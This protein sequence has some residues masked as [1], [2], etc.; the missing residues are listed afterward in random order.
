MQHS[1]VKSMLPTVLCA[2]L[3]LMQLMLLFSVASRLCWWWLSHGQVRSDNHE[4]LS[5][6]STTL[7][8]FF[9]YF[10]PKAW[11]EIHLIRFHIL[12]VHPAFQSFETTWISILSSTVILLIYVI[13]CY[14][15]YI[16]L[17]WFCI[18]SNLESD[19]F[20][21]A[22]DSHPVFSLQLQLIDPCQ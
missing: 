10:K 15:C 3:L 16:L 11:L 18:I 4:L 17:I 21:L 6:L 2:Q 19:T 7:H 14:I 22:H 1:K 5:A 8:L 13:Y 9:S 20:S 12:G